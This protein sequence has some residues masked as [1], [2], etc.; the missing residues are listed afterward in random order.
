[1]ATWI[2]PFYKISDEIIRPWIP[3]KIINP[4]N[5]KTINILALLDTGADHCVFPKFVAE[6]AT[7]DLKADAISNETMQGLAETKIEV[8][9]HAFKIHLLSPD[10]KTVVCK[11]KDLI[12]GC[13]DHDNIP[14]ILGFSNFMC[15]FKITFNHATK[16]II[17]DDRPKI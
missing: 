5:D 12:V 17:I 14:P 10:Q 6:Q 15:D 9:K 8:W 3:I 16:K 7:L 2:Y 4:K 11:S 1:M 13:V